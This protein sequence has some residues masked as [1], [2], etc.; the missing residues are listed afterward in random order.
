MVLLDQGGFLNALNRIYDQSKDKGSV[1]V[2]F[3]KC[4]SLFLLQT[5]LFF[6]VA[7]DD[8]LSKRHILN[9]YTEERRV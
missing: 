1:R 7:L 6:F 3:K 9:R 8:C 4:T 5:S 2:T